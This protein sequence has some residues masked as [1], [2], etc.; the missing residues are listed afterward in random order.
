MAPGLPIE[1]RA[2]SCRPEDIVR[3][4]V[5]SCVV[6]PRTRQQLAAE[7]IGN[8]GACRAFFSLPENCFR[9]SRIGR[10]LRYHGWN[11]IHN[12]PIVNIAKKPL[13]SARA[14]IKTPAK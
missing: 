12:N 11:D 6:H 1:C 4:I 2:R 10:R 3:T 14:Q 5:T 7:L 9:C 13:I 8:S